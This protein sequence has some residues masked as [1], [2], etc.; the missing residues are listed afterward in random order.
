MKRMLLDTIHGFYLEALGMLPT[1]E[2][3]CRHHRSMLMAGYCY[4]PLDP[5]TIKGSHQTKNFLCK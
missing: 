2:L 4:G 5:G 3:L 1:D